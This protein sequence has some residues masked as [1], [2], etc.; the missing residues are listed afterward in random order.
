MIKWFYRGV[1]LFISI[2]VVIL[3]IPI[4]E[5]ILNKELPCI[6]SAGD[7]RVVNTSKAYQLHDSNLTFYKTGKEE[8]ATTHVVVY[9]NDGKHHDLS[10]SFKD[11]KTEVVKTVDMMSFKAYK[12]KYIYYEHFIIELQDGEI[13]KCHLNCSV[14]SIAFFYYAVVYI[15]TKQFVSWISGRYFE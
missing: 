14:E 1:Y 8:N 10:K 9:D 7:C 15:K 5:A 13:R 6:E 3:S 12:Q 11:E 2:I 4:M